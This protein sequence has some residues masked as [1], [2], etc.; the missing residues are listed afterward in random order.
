[1]SKIIRA[2][3]RTTIKNGSFQEDVM[4]AGRNVGLFVGVLTMGGKRPFR[5]DTRRRKARREGSR[6]QEAVFCASSVLAKSH[7]SPIVYR[8]LPGCLR[9]ARSSGRA[10]SKGEGNEGP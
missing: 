8:T 9:W 4:L 1:M 5:G 7:L 3:N 6:G 2:E 10:R